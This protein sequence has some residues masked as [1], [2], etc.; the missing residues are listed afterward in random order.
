MGNTSIV[1]SDI[2]IVKHNGTR[3]G[4]VVPV[5]KGLGVASQHST[6]TCTHT[7]VSNIID[8]KNHT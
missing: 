1:F 2:Y 7:D 4:R 8:K 3:Y 5:T 6:T